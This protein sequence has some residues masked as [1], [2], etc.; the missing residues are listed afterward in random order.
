MF[1]WSTQSEFVKKT[2]KT[3]PFFQGFHCVSCQLVLNAFSHKRFSLFPSHYVLRADDRTDAAGHVCVLEW[4]QMWVV[5]HAARSTAAERQQHIRRIVSITDSE[6]P[7]HPIKFQSPLSTFQA[8]W[9][10]DKQ[11]TWRRIRGSG[12]WSRVESLF[13]RSPFLHWWLCLV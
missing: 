5:R 7:S 3:K 11:P 2:K 13:L 9:L 6:L 10:P 8:L 4:L 1:W 12:S